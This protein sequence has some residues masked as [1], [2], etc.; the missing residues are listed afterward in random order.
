MQ[1][2]KRHVNTSVKKI[3]GSFQQELLLCLKDVQLKKLN[4]KKAQNQL[5][6]SHV[7]IHLQFMKN[8]NQACDAGIAKWVWNPTQFSC[9][10]SVEKCA[11][12]DTCV[13]RQL[14]DYWFS[15]GD[16][17]VSCTSFWWLNVY[18]FSMVDLADW[19]NQIMLGPESQKQLALPRIIAS[20]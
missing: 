18:K 13:Q 10:N 11:S 17:S 5:S 16:S 14:N 6:I 12:W 9:S 4:S 8:L 1:P 3:S 2:F 19:Y 15:T 20:M 7:L